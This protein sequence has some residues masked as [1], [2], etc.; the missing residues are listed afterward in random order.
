MVSTF[1]Y[2]IGW[3]NFQSWI[4][5]VVLITIS[6]PN[7]DRQESPERQQLGMHPFQAFIMGQKTFAVKL[8]AELTFISLL[9]RKRREGR[10]KYR[11]L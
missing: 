7:Q 5:K 2:D 10:K 8:A 6:A 9:W 4:H 1:I 3:E 11:I